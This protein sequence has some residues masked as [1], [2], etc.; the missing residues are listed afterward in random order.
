[1]M[2]ESHSA[3]PTSDPTLLLLWGIRLLVRHVSNHADEVEDTIA[4]AARALGSLTLVGDSAIA[5]ANVSSSGG[6]TRRSGE[7]RRPTVLD[8]ARGRLRFQN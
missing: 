7:H 8:T 6:R 2:R 4:F 3:G 5:A 1:M